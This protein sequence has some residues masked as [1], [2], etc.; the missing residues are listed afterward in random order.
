MVKATTSIP[1]SDIILDETIYPRDR[2]ARRLGLVRETIRNH[3]A[4]MPTLA[5]WPNTD[6]SRG[7][8][9]SQE[10]EKHGWT[11]PMVWSLKNIEYWKQAN[12]PVHPFNIRISGRIALYV[13]DRLGDRY[14]N[15]RNN[16]RYRPRI[17]S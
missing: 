1:I 7:F 5:F 9:A 4:K 13:N 16:W 15:N 14:E 2:I 11:E 12:P 3:L 10:V 6:L 8:T 17:D